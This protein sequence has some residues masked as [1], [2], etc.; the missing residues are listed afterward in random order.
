M[1]GWNLSIGG[2]TEV[3]IHHVDANGAY[4]FVARFKHARPKT[5]AKAFA[6]FLQ[7]NF[8]P[9]EYFARYADGIP[10]LTILN[11]KGYVS[12]NQLRAARFAAERAPDNVIF[13]DVTPAAVRRLDAETA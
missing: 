9:A 11:E 6:K 10:P 2:S 13:I 4:Q 5:N 8:T 7:A 12:P 1:R 3:Y